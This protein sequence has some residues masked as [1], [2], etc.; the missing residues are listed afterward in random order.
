MENEN[1]Y[2]PSSI[3]D[4][5][6]SIPLY[7]RLFEWTEKQINQLLNDLFSSYSQNKTQPYYIGMLTVYKDS[8]GLYVLVDGQQRFTVL[9]L[10]GI[11]FNTEVW[12]KFA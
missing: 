8:K 6:F 1:K 4:Q 2:T 3:E 10:M 7:Q 12:N 11:A 9:M 5:K